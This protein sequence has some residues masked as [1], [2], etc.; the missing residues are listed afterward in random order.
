MA[1]QADDRGL[2]AVRIEAM[3]HGPGDLA[4]EIERV[5]PARPAPVFAA[6]TDPDQL[7]KWWG[8]EGFVIPSLDF[9]ARAGESYRIEMQPPDGGAFYLA[10]EF[11]E[12][13]PPQRL[14]FT[15]AWEEPDPD[16]VENLVALSFGNLGES[17]EVSLEQAPFRTEARR[18]L[19]RDGWTDSLDKLDRLLSAT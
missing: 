12:V 8:P 6:F 1:Q 2:A 10:G 19:H 18:E 4:L 7:V 3:E 14:T 11:R 15:F 5:L 13:T 17:T 9:P 16:D